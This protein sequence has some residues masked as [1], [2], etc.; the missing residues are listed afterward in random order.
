MALK[1]VE[2]ILLNSSVDIVSCGH[3]TYYWYGVESNDCVE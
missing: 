2:E 1:A 3:G